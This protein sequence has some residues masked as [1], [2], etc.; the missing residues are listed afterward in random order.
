VSSVPNDLY[1]IHTNVDG[2]AQFYVP[3]PEE[4]KIVTA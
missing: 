3:I 4:C 1:N 2:F